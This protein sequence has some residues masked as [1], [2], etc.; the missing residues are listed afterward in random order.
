MAGKS[1]GSIGRVALFL[2]IVLCVGN[3][4]L[5]AGGKPATKLV[6]VADTRTME[7]GPSKWIADVYNTNL[8]AYAALVVL[9]MSSLG[10][11]LG[12]G[13]DRLLVLMGLELSRL[14]HHE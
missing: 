7:P 13:F 4:A 1:Y 12:Y 10:L 11:I 2:T 3:L 14:E 6:N 9:V 8:W 5:A